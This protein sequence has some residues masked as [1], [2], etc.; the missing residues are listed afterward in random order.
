MSNA[1]NSTSYGDTS[2]GST[3]DIASLREFKSDFAR[4]VAPLTMLE[5]ANESQVLELLETFPESIRGV[6][7]YKALFHLSTED[8]IETAN[9]LSK[10]TQ[11]QESEDEV[12]VYAQDAP[13]RIHNV[14]H[15]LFRA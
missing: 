10:I 3:D 11:Y 6:V 1:F 12:P 4:S 7:V 9:H 13:D 5:Q 2:S 14:A 8:P 15:N